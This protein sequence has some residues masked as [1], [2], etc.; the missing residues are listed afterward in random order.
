MATNSPTLT[1]IGQ[2]ILIVDGV[3]LSAAE[4]S[5]RLSALGAKVHVAANPVSAIRFA[6]SKRFDV[7]LV[8][9]GSFENN[10]LLLKAL[11][12]RGIPHVTCASSSRREYVDYSHVFSLDLA[13][14]T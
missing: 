14:V 12:R 5:N 4:L 2:S 7:A 8:G 6:E 1:L 3:N 13:P 11:E 10:H 9:F